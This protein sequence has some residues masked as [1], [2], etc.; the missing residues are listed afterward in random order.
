M[1][2]IVRVGNPFIKCL[3]N[4]GTH[5]YIIDKDKMKCVYCNKILLINTK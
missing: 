1:N 3:F 2:N 5:Q 4:K